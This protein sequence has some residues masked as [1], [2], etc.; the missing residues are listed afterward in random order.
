LHTG[1][2]RARKVHQQEGTPM[3]TYTFIWKLRDGDIHE[4]EFRGYEC[5]IDA[6]DDWI[7]QHGINMDE[8]EWMKVNER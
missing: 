5:E 1:S 8:I 3:T 2:T 4:Q 7:V 6:A